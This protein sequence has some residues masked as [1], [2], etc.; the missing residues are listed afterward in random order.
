[1][2]ENEILTN[3]ELSLERI[4]N[5][6]ERLQKTIAG[7]REKDNDN[8][9]HIKEI[10][11]DLGEHQHEL[12]VLAR[13]LEKPETVKR[14]DVIVERIV[15]YAK[16]RHGNMKSRITVYSPVDLNNSNQYFSIDRDRNMS[17]LRRKGTI[18]RELYQW[19]ED[20]RYAVLTLGN[21]GSV[22]RQVML[23]DLEE[24]EVLAY[25]STLVN[26]K[27]KELA[28]EQN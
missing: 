3:M 9:A 26:E 21:I 15:K 17:E 25:G 27:I 18:Y 1:M 13:L 6:S 10:I 22:G 11:E 8:T 19:K 7:M 24:G 12:A 14:L 20:N 4:E 5:E 28:E 16:T 2:L 23:Y